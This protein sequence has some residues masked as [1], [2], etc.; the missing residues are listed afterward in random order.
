MYKVLV[1]ELVPVSI[2]W[3]AFKEA[4]KEEDSDE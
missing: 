1:E 4:P 2:R 3:I